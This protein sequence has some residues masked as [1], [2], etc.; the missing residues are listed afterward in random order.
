MNKLNL[1]L[2]ANPLEFAAIFGE[3]TGDA[4]TQ[5]GAD[6][7]GS[8]RAGS[9]VSRSRSTSRGPLGTRESRSVSNDSVDAP[10]ETLGSRRQY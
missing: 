10:I 1:I 6:T 5:A 4:E 8:R 3:V 2:T 7:T 9:E